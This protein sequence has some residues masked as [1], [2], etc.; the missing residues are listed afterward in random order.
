MSLTA[1]LALERWALAEPFV[2]AREVM[3]D[4]PL[5]HLRLTDADGASGHAE[6]AG[7][8][9]DGETP[10]SIAAQIRAVSNRLHADITATELNALLPAGGARNAVDCALWDLRAKRHGIRAATTAAV[11]PLKPVTTAMTIG[12]GSADDIRRRA[13]AV[14]EHRLI[15]IKVDATR[16]LEHV[17]IVAD[18]I[19][20]ARIVID[21]NEG[22]TM[23]LL[24]SLL[25]QLAREGVEAVEQPLPRG[26]DQALAGWRPPVMLIADESC[27]DTASLD[28]LGD[29]YQG[30]N[31]KLDK[32]GGLTEAL[33]LARAARARG[34]AVMVGNMCGTSLGM[35]PAFLVAQLARWVDLDGPLLQVDDRDHAMRYEHGLLYPPSPELW[36]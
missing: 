18:I 5:V 27:T 33:S 28:A 23:A 34:L 20:T 22:W 2:I 26:A 3:R 24:E 16:H 19:P 35:A 1:E 15:K 6:A 31:V 14:R 17:K 11:A 29:R 7:V 25:P 12:L 4:V 10:A 36:G 13:E 32:C 30:V 9:Y 21:A 8:D